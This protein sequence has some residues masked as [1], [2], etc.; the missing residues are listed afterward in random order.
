MKT[1]TLELL[2]IIPLAEIKDIG[3]PF[4]KQL[5]AKEQGD[6]KTTKKMENFWDYFEKTWLGRYKPDDWNISYFSTVQNSTNNLLESYN[7]KIMKAFPHSPPCKNMFVHL[8][9]KDS[10][11]YEFLMDQVRRG[12]RVP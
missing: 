8:I 10:E 4:I 12:E 11:E 2:T 1:D 3:I 9:R 6:E 5:L 7:N